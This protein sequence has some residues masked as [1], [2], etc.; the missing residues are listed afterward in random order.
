MPDEKRKAKPPTT[1]QLLKTIEKEALEKGSYNISREGFF[2]C[3]LRASFVRA[4]QFAAYCNKIKWDT[5]DE[6]AFFMASALR[7]TCEDL[8]ALK[9]I[10]Q[11]PRQL[12]DEVI[13][14]EMSLAVDKAIMEQTKFFQKERPFQQV[15]SHSGDGSFVEKKKDRLTDIATATGLWNPG[16]Q[17]KLPPMQQMAIKLGMRE[18]YDYFY[19]VTSDVVHFNPRI[20]LRSGWGPDPKRGKFNTANFARYYLGFCQVYS[21]MLFTMMA[22][23]F[24]RDLSLS[25]EFREGLAKLEKDL[26]KE[27]R[28]PEAVTFE[29]M[30]QKPPSI[31]LTTLARVMWDDPAQRRKWKREMARAA[32]KAAAPTT[33]TVPEEALAT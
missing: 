19:R 17:K 2:R 27:M 10:R 20:S 16:K 26:D 30:N 33:A 24:A 1:F 6:G 23:A 21:V 12:R 32:V 15:I 9:F 4:Y 7:G 11:L 3:A 13:V 31:I 28:W 5:A 18:E 29:E 22:R 25:K 8:I 14:I